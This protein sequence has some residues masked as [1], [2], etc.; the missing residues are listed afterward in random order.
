M[1]SLPASQTAR[2]AREA[3]AQLPAIRLQRSAHLILYQVRLIYS[4]AYPVLLLITIGAALLLIR[5]YQPE[6]RRF[7]YVGFEVFLP[8]AASF[9]FVPLILREQQQRTLAL[10]SVTQCSLPFLFIIRLV[11]NILFLAALVVTLGLLLHLSPPTPDWISSPP[12]A[13]LE[14]D[15]SVWPV[16]LA[17]GPNGIIAVLLTLLAPTFLLAGIGAALA[18]LTADARVGY[19]AIFAVWFLNRV[20]G[21]VLDTHP[22]LHNFYLFVRS[23]GTGDWLLP[24]L[25]QLSSGIGLLLLAWLLLRKPERLLRASL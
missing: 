3:D 10:V 24:K 25:T 15:L 23:S 14:R 22:L 1:K 9:L 13:E 20:A 4:W 21:V 17:G 16:R 18:H 11:L 12:D 6:A 19:L 5:Q 2:T 7:F 8:L